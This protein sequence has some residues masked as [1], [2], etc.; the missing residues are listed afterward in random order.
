MISQRVSQ[1]VPWEVPRESLSVE[2]TFRLELEEQE[3]ARQVNI[4]GIGVWVEGS[5]LKPLGRNNQACL[6]PSE[7]AHV[8]E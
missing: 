2:M 7:G 6:G 5:T 3:A 8:F 4:Q 1:E